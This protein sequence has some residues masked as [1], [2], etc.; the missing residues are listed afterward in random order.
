MASSTAATSQEEWLHSV[1]VSVEVA[2]KTG[3]FTTL[4]IRIHRRNDIADEATLQSIRDWHRYV[5]DG[6]ESPSGSAISPV[7]NWCTFIFPESLDE[8]LHSVT[9]LANIGNIH[10]AE[11]L[12]LESALEEHKHFSD[13]LDGNLATL[14]NKEAKT[15]KMRQ[16]VSDCV[17][18]ILTLDREMG[19]RMIESYRKKWLDVMEDPDYDAMQSLDQYL[20]FR[21]LNGGMEPFW[22]MCQ[23]GMGI[24]ISEED[25]QLE[26]EHI[27]WVTNGS[28]I[29]NSIEVLSRNQGISF[30]EARE[31][32]RAMIVGY[33]A[34][35]VRRKDSYIRDHPSISSAMRNFIDVCGLVVAGNHYWCANCPRHHAWKKNEAPA[36]TEAPTRDMETIP[37]PV[38]VGPNVDSSPA[39]SL[40]PE[41]SDRST[42][43][44]AASATSVGDDSLTQQPTPRP[45]KK[46]KFEEIAS[47]SDMHALTRNH[48]VDAPCRYI[49]SLPSKG[50]RTTFIDALNQWFQ[51]KTETL[52]IVKD[53]T[54]ALH[55]ASLILDDVQDASP[56]RRGR[57]ATHAVFGVA[58]SVNSATY[59]F[60]RA[61]ASVQA[62][63]DNGAHTEF[64]EILQRMHVGQGYDLHWK[65]YSSC[66]SEQDYLDMVDGK[67]G[68]MFELIVALMAPKSSKFSSKSAPG[69]KANL[70]ASDAKKLLLGKE[71]EE[72]SYPFRRLTRLFGRFFQ[73]RDDFMNLSSDLYAQGKGFCEDLDE[74]KLSFL[75]VTCAKRDPEAFRQI[76]GIFRARGG[77][78]GGS[79]SAVALLT[80]E[81]KTYILSLLENS[82]TLEATRTWLVDLESQLETEIGDL[83]K[84]YGTQNSMLRVLVSTLSVKQ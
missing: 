69:T 63:F 60:V 76:M 32:V 10:D 67:T 46:R 80:G 72:E 71:V 58:Q 75:L 42:P 83:E 17:L 77:G 16:L 62:H 4:P 19:M 51:V 40:T 18:Q 12:T 37:P 22:L 31:S 35:Y 50:V 56:L 48:P 81:A 21:M 79:S 66:P 13:A 57:P 53:V 6:W 64:L 30:Y 14:S 55:N 5:G 68:A 28:R 47:P 70:T 43:L 61:V 11:D 2:R 74:E 49:A 39:T 73:V 54:K 25:L 36:T 26:R 44:D 15:I 9:Y 3:C 23:F 38:D 65:F 20:A 52:D 29:V 82:G 78:G 34:E 8:R 84:Q 59:L 7:G 41:A 33:E 1:E 45:T 24:N 27:A